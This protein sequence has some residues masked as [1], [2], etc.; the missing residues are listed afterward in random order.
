MCILHD[1][2]DNKDQAL[3]KKT[4]EEKTEKENANAEYQKVDLSGVVFPIDADFRGILFRKVVNFADARFQKGANFSGVRFAE[5]GFFRTKFKGQADFGDS[6]FRGSVSFESATFCGVADFSGVEFMEVTHFDETE[7][8]AAARFGKTIFG[9]ATGFNSTKFHSVA[10]FAY[11]E[12]NRGVGFYGAHFSDHAD[13]I[14]VKFR[15][16]SYFANT[17]FAGTVSFHNAIFNE[18]ANFRE[19]VFSGAPFVDFNRITVKSA[20]NFHHTVFP[21]GESTAVVNFHYL[22]PDSAQNVRLEGVDLSKVSF[23]RADVSQV[24]FVGCTWAQKISLRRWPDLSRQLG[25]SRNVLYDELD[26]DERRKRGEDVETLLPLVAELYRQ[27]RLNLDASRLEVEAGNFYVGQMEMRRQDRKGYPWLY[28]RVLLAGYRVLA[29]YG[30][31]FVRPLAL[32][33]L[34]G[35]L[36]AF[37]YLWGGFL[38]TTEKEVNYTFLD[39][40]PGNIRQF[41]QDYIRALAHALTAG[42]FFGTQLDTNSWWVPS[43]RY[44]NTL[45]D[46][47]LLGLTLVA[48]RRHFRR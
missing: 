19:A 29:M 21:P 6:E 36:L 31:S 30:E 40:D 22:T 11:A 23:L 16:D 20:L 46:L 42:G 9:R 39:F 24:R 12:F 34:L 33:F 27:I 2:D 7:F 3:F 44:M 1:P 4:L 13:F 17:Q 15:S 35:G 48:L 10:D 32:Y 43:V 38:I 8:E 5:A 18:E 41:G 26:L 47:F 45:A 14:S 28:R 37:P 25:Q